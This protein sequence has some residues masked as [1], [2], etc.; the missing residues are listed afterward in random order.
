MVGIGAGVGV[1][2]GVGTG[3]KAGVGVDVGSAWSHAAN[4][5]ATR[6]SRPRMMQRLRADYI[7]TRR[8]VHTS[9]LALEGAKVPC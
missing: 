3:V 5:A 2:V 9:L 6:A 7:P 4:M 1:A 8:D